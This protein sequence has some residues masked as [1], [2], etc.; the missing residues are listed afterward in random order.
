MYQ[1]PDIL[2]CIH[3]K[4]EQDVLL[5]GLLHPLHR[6]LTDAL[7]QYTAATHP[8]VIPQPHNTTNFRVFQ[9]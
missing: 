2:Q 8:R 4:P 1:Q 7:S 5:Q 6:T 3:P 9:G